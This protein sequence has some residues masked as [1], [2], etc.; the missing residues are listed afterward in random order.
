M[1][2]VSFWG[3]PG[4]SASL[5][6]KLIA[7]PEIK[8]EYIVTQ[9]DKPRS[10]RGRELQPT[11]VKTAGLNHH[12]PVFTPV[13][14]KKN[15]DEFFNEIKNYQVNVNVVF[16]YGK[17]IPERFFSMPPGGT[18]N[19]HASLLPRFRGASPIEQALFEGDKIT[20]WA[21][22]RMV[23][24][25]DAGDIYYN[26]EIDVAWEDDFFSLAEKLMKA[27]LEFASG[28]IVDYAVGKL[29]GRRQDE[30]TATHCGKIETSE[31]QIDWK[32]TFEKIRNI[33]RA[34]TGRGGIYSYYMKKR[35]KLFT[36]LNV[37]QSEIIKASEESIPGEIYK[38]TEN[39][40]WVVCADRLCLPVNFVQPEGKKKLTIKEFVNG[41][42]IE[43]GQ[44]FGGL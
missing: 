44:G 31:G 29:T 11:P 2:R 34:M 43:A 23:E 22:Q 14:L 18:L 21:M 1:I 4:I 41:Y 20:G 28:V 8:V 7:S 25:L 38:I 5:L 13:S 42:R 33:A 36:D 10:N 32:N 9:Q 19:F 3:S 40:L 12:I 6:E 15:A 35:I 17:I 26:R 24:Q 30:T 39:H 16:A 37:A 27:L